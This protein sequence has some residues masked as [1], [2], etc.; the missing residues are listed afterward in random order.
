MSA[1]VQGYVI[2]STDGSETTYLAFRRFW[3]SSRFEGAW[4]HDAAPSVAECA[5]WETKPSDFCRATW[6]EDDGN[7]KVGDWNPWPPRATG[8][9]TS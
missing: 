8:E 6:S 4:V 2:R 5:T 9:K 1:T 3:F 7:M